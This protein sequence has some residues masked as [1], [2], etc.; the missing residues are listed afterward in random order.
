ME[1]TL[2]RCDYEWITKVGKPKE[3]QRNNSY[4]QKSE[5]YDAKKNNFK[6]DMH[7]SIIRLYMGSQTPVDDYLYYIETTL[8]VRDVVCY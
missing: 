4:Y 5:P 8:G 7:I 2:F 6:V 1:L 3:T